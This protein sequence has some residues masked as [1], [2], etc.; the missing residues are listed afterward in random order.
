MAKLAPSFI[1]VGLAVAAAAGCTTVSPRIALL[2]TCDT[3][4]STLTSLAAAK[5][6]GRLS[7]HQI[8]AVDTVRLGLNPICESPPVLDDSVASVLPHVKEGVRQLLLIE[9]QVEIADDAR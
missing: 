2:Q 7:A 8:E 5:A 3:Y 4:A 6:H 1:A 9:A